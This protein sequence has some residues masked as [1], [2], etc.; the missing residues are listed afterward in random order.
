LR[1]PVW[2]IALIASMS[3][4]V[5]AASA[6]AAKLPA[7]LV[8]L[9]QKMQALRL[10]TARGTIVEVLTG[11]SL[12]GESL[13]GLAPH[14]RSGRDRKEAVVH[15]TTH[16]KQS[17]PFVTADFE[18]SDSPKLAVIRGTILGG[19]S[20][21][22]RV[23]GEELYM[24]SPLLTAIDGGKPWVSTS[25]AER[26]QEQG[27]A[28]SGEE[29][30]SP[31]TSTIAESGFRKLVALLSHAGSVVEV[32]PRE[33]DGQ[34]TI[35][36]EAK[37]DGKQLLNAS[38]TSKP[39]KAKKKELE[40]ST[41]TFDLFLADDGLPVRTRIQTQIGKAEISVV[42]DIL[43]TEVSVSVQ[44]PPASETIT[45]AELRKQEEKSAKVHLTKRERREIA[46]FEACVKRH[47][48][49]SGRST[50]REIKKILRE[51]PAPK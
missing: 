50:S 35:E 45:E 47:R 24:R 7:D 32:G 49:K 4:G 25:P 20:F 33:V 51:C 16:P 23:I 9:E 13:F 46:H 14:R 18:E 12:G 1:G 6:S 28:Q 26:A 41:L 17:L 3:I 38:S 10:N 2:L 5:G 48:P 27:R 11:A 31:P 30:V 19:L 29:D 42:E 40:R 34:Q 22:E 44:P 36:F 21:Q 39:S 15:L 8:E 43:A 37:L